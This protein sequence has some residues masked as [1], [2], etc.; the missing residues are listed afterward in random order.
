MVEF[1][2]QFCF[3]SRG[4]LYGRWG[5][6]YSWK[7]TVFHCIF[8]SKSTPVTPALT[9]SELKPFCVSKNWDFFLQF[10]LWNSSPLS[11]PA[12]APVLKPLQSASLPPDWLDAR[13]IMP[14]SWLQQ[15][16][17]APKQVKLQALFRCVCSQGKLGSLLLLRLSICSHNAS[18]FFFFR[19]LNHKRRLDKD[20]LSQTSPEIQGRLG[21]SLS[22]AS[23]LP[24]CAKSFAYFLAV[25]CT[26]SLWSQNIS[27]CPIISR[28]HGRLLSLCV[29][30][31]SLHMPSCKKSA[32]KC[33]SPLLNPPSVKV[34]VCVLLYS[35]F[36]G[37]WWPL[38]SFP[39]ALAFKQLELGF[40]CSS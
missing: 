31:S 8:V 24:L 18:F 6:V 39:R 10:K 33:T 4:I 36:D 25:Y 19:E 26:E 23:A 40:V 16:G 17:N 27:R 1:F 21:N 37:G 3:S 22:A 13:Q 9:N 38:R 5:W 30:S 7:V 11:S 2:C 20:A 15:T 14:L 28:H 12:A 34:Q 32:Q 29:G 35:P